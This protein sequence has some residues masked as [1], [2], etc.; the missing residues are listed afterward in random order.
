MAKGA[1]APNVNLDQLD[2][3]LGLLCEALLPL[4]ADV[5]QQKALVRVSAYK[6]AEVVQKEPYE[7]H[8]M[9]STAPV[10]S[11]TVR[12]LLMDL[13][14]GLQRLDSK[15]RSARENYFPSVKATDSQGPDTPPPSDLSEHV[16]A[17]LHLFASIEGNLDY[18]RE[19]LS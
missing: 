4:A 7:G 18:L 6:Q 13:Y 3:K 9:A 19:R 15:T 5:Y 17:C 8:A 2:Q 1:K 11:G 12:S 16:S 14:I 10:P